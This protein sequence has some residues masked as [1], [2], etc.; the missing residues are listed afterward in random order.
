MS[1]YLLVGLLL[2]SA[3]G[4]VAIIGAIAQSQDGYEDG[5]VFHLIESAD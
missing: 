3:A 2:F 5:R 4:L 1:I